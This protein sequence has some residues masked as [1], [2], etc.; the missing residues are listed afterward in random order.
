MIERRNLK[1]E[2]NVFAPFKITSDSVVTKFVT[3]K[4]KCPKRRKKK[5]ETLKEK[6]AA[7]TK[8]RE[9]KY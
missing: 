4:W 9:K 5:E 8:I 7:R 2:N 1:I 3:K 6:R